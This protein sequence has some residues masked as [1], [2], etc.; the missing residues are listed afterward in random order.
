M[1]FKFTAAK[2]TEIENGVTN[3]YIDTISTKK[4]WF[5]LPLAIGYA[6][7]VLGVWGYGAYVAIKQ[8]LG[9]INLA[10][11]LQTKLISVA[12]TL[13]A[14]YNVYEIARESETLLSAVPSLSEVRL[15]QKKS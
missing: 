12:S 10:K 11:Y 3:D 14:I 2:I 6:A 1:K 7:L 8:E 13:Q 4:K 5:A 15:L 9:R